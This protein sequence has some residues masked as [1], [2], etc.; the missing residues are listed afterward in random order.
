[1]GNYSRVSISKL[2][3]HFR[4]MSSKMRTSREIRFDLST[5]SSNLRKLYQGL[6]RLILNIG[7]VFISKIDKQTKIKFEEIFLL[8]RGFF[9]DKSRE[10]S[11]ALPKLFSGVSGLSQ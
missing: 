11:E 10:I 1:M 8:Q 2:K 5:I 9:R 3:C 6:M 4:S 7:R